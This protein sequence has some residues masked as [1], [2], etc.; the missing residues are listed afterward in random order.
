MAHPS[1]EDYVDHHTPNIG[2]APG[3]PLVSYPV[4]QTWEIEK[5]AREDWWALDR[6]WE[7][8][9]RR[10]ERERE[11]RE[12]EAAEAE[13]VVAP[14]VSTSADWNAI[15]L[16]ESSGN[17]AETEGI[18]EGGLQFLPSTWDAYAP[19]EYPDAAYLATP[20]Q[21]VYVGELVL[22][23]QGAEAWPNCFVA[24]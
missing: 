14:V 2:L 13:A 24:V 4:W 1:L 8:R 3:T 21:Q 17:W 10:L 20:A 11:A 15:A 7:A 16:C 12:A 23:A 5:Q 19:A 6:R 9:Q 18:F 22:Q